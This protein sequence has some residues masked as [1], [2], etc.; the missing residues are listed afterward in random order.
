MKEKA[1]FNK[2][3]MKQL[4]NS[5]FKEFDKQTNLITY[6]NVIANTQN[7]SYIRAYNNTTC[8]Y[9]EF[10][11]GYL[12]ATDLQWF[13]GVNKE[14]VK[15]LSKNEPVI[16]YQFYIYNK[17]KEKDVIGWIVTD[18]KH[19]KVLYRELRVNTEKRFNCLKYLERFITL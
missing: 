8:N 14:K 3:G 11:K 15:E 16:L 6:G 10:E 7:S 9:N 12:Q 4:T 5:G 17:K 13:N 2:N 19:E 18:T 1:I